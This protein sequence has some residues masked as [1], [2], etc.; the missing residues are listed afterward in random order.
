MSSEIKPLVPEMDIPVFSN[1][2][3]V[4]LFDLSKSNESIEDRISTVTQVASA[5][6]N[7]E[8]ALSP[9]V[10]YDKL[11]EERSTPLEFVRLYPKYDIGSSLRNETKAPID[12]IITR[13][14]S[15]RNAVACV[16]FRAPLMVIAHIVRHR[17]FSYNQCSRRYTRVKK[18][19]LFIPDELV[20]NKYFNESLDSSFEAYEH[21]IKT[22]HKPEIARSVLPAYCIMSDM[23]MIGDRI[24]WNSFFETRLHD[25]KERVQSYTR[26]LAETIYH[27]ILLN[28]P[29]IIDI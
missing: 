15:H 12:P 3:Y 2:G 4:Q 13:R 9:L 24:A 5:S 22:G 17:S 10:L 6:F 20:T 18:E 7:K 21:L 19:D 16:K 23:W 27:I 1:Y 25:R 14:K 26:H 29:S 28:Q 8:K 11:L